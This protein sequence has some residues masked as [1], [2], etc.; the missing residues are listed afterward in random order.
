[1]LEYPPLSTANE[2]MRPGAL[3]LFVDSLEGGENL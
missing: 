3:S 1:M 2:Q